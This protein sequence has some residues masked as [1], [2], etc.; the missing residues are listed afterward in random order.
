[1]AELAAGL[2]GP[3]GERLG[4]FPTGFTAVLGLPGPW[5]DAAPGEAELLA[6]RVPADLRG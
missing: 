4:A 5:A 3:A 2:A 1:M 6:F